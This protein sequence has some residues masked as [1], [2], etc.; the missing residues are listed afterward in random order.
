MSDKTRDALLTWLDL[1]RTSNHIKKN[2][3]AKLRAEFGQSLS[4]FDVL[5]SLERGNRDGIRS[6]EL[7]RQM[8]VT[9]G[10][11]TQLMSK[12]IRDGLVHKRPD[13]NDARVVIY[14]LSD[15]GADLFDR[16][17]NA[18]RVWIQEIFAELG[19][20]ELEEFRALLAQL[21]TKKNIKEVA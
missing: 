2:V 18:H 1:L 7:S 16:M 10:N 13:E 17:A 5:S 14:S 11:I 19:S 15:E 4:R 12:L 21:S 3:E 9:E 20:P 6:G 8:V